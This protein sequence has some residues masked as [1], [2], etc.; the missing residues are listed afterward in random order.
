VT[1]CHETSFQL[2]TKSS[3]LIGSALRKRLPLLE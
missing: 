1:T 3:A 2:P